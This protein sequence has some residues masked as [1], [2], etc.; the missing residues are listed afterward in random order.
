MEK[1]LKEENLEI[2]SWRN[3]PVKSEVLGKD[4]LKTEP[5]IKQIFLKKDWISKQIECLKILKKKVRI[6]FILFVI[7]NVFWID[8]WSGGGEGRDSNPRVTWITAAGK[9]AAALTNGD[10]SA[11]QARPSVY[12]PK[13]QH[14]WQGR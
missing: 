2:I 5:C 14:I 6:K 13:D 11:V 8:F 3:V 10:L 1:I 12:R 7:N 4:A 9:P